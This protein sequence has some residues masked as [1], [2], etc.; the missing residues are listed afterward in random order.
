MEKL[1]E[2]IIKIYGSRG[3]S[4]LAGL[5]RSVEQLKDAWGLSRL[6]PVSNLSYSY[7]L[8][9]FQGDA[10]II[11]KLSPD[12]DLT[13]KE[14]RALD[15]FKGFG[16]AFVLGCKDGVLLLERAVPGSLLKNR[17]PKENRIEIACKVMERLHQAPPPSKGLFPHIEEWLAAIDK[18]WEL[19]KEHL[20]RARKLKKNLLKNDSASEI[21][22]HGDLHQ[23]NILSHG[24]DWVVIDPKGVI[25]CPIH[26]VWA[27]VEDP[28]QDLR[29][30]SGYFGYPFQDVAEWYYIHL[31]LAACWQAEDGLDASRFLA[32]AQSILPMIEPYSS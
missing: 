9:G 18:E 31:I 11:L 13:G 19:P 24:N 27:C 8:E 1:K 7:V 14:A 12:D 22:L 4:W 30:L 21:L 29:F 5:P 10:P 26:E 15:A 20:E 2:N 6:K 25:G 16:A 3:E 32:L 23:E 17:D 28:Q